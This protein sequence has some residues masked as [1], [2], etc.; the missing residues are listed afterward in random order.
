[1]SRLFGHGDLRLWLLKL[2]DERPRH[3]Y[4]II[5]G[6]EEQFLGVYSPSPG[7][8]YP[9]LAALEGEGLIEVVDE[10]EGRKV[11][12]LTDTGRSELRER[13][14]E[15]KQL[16]ERLARSARDIAREIREDVRSSVRDLR[17]Q[18]KEAARDVRREERYEF[19]TTRDADRRARNVS[20]QRYRAAREMAREVTGELRSVLRSL[21]ADLD[22]F[23]AD[24]LEAARRRE[25]DRE[26]LESTLRD[27]IGQARAVILEA[28]EGE[29]KKRP[30]DSEPKG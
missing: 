4:D 12:A 20:R 14:D 6:L 9:R 21:Q 18:I 13:T 23:V 1:M 25:L 30:A 17:R 24:V 28:L 5:A 10:E 11:Y 15:L 29:E 26:R 2:L 7:T 27:A 22:G 3:G 16:G 8:V 19:R